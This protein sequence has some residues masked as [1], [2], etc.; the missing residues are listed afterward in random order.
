MS[1]QVREGLSG[2]GL[3][4]HAV[5]VGALLS[6]SGVLPHKHNVHFALI[7]SERRLIH[8]H[9]S[10]VV[11]SDCKLNQEA[12]NDAT[13]TDTKADTVLGPVEW[14]APDGDTSKLHQENLNNDGDGDNEDEEPVVEEVSKDVEIITQLTAVD[15]VEHLHEHESLEYHRIYDSLVLLQLMTV[16]IFVVFEELSVVVV[17]KI[18]HGLSCEE[19][20]Q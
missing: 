12:P 13:G 17:W 4:E 16:S 1:D 18:E 11:W 10:K 15:L 14:V 20:H 6:Q 2:F 8:L 9:V 5:L 19:K 3:A 7:L